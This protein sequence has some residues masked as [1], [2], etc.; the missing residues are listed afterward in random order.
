MLGSACWVVFNIFTRELGWFSWTPKNSVFVC[1]FVFKPKCWVRLVGLFFI[2]FYPGAGLF[3]Y[4]MAG[5]ILLGSFW[6]IGRGINRQLK[7][8][9]PSPASDETEFHFL[10]PLQRAVLGATAAGLVHF[11]SKI[12]TFQICIHFISFIKSLLCCK[13]IIS[14]NA[15]YKDEMS[16]RNASAAFGRFLHNGNAFCRA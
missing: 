6:A 7:Q 3:F 13:Y 5:L 4:P 8:V 9:H 16:V 1:L 15:T 10:S 12:K 11:F 2:C 14:C